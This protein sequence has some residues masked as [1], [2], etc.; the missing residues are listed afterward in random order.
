MRT[1]VL[2]GMLLACGMVVVLGSEN[3]NRAA[4]GTQANAS[5][6]TEKVK[7]EPEA[8]KNETL[9]IAVRG[10]AL[11]SDGKPISGAQIYLASVGEMGKLVA[12]TKTDGEGRYEFRS[13]ELP[14]QDFKSVGGAKHGEFQVFGR[15]S[16]YGF[17]WY[18][19]R[20]LFLKP[21]PAD[22]DERSDE[23]VPQPS[24]RFVVGD[25][26]EIDLSFLPAAK[27]SGRI[28]DD[29]AKPITGAELTI[30]GCEPLKDKLGTWQTGFSAVR[31]RSAVVPTDMKTCRTSDTGRFEFRGLPADCR[32][33]IN[34]HAEGF[35]E[36]GIWAATTDKPQPAEPQEPVVLTGDLQLRFR[37]P[38]DVPVKV[39]YGDTRKPAPRVRVTFYNSTD[40]A[41]AATDKEGLATLR[42]APGEYELSL[43]PVRGTS[44][45]ST[46]GILNPKLE[47][48]TVPNDSPAEPIVVFLRTGVIV[49]VKVVEAET[50][51]GVPHVDLWRQDDAN[52]PYNPAA[53]WSPGCESWD[54]D[55]QA[56]WAERPRTDKD[57]KL[58]G[59]FKSGVYRLG[60][61][62][63]NISAGFE[64]VE[65]EGQVVECAAGKPVSLKFTMRK[66]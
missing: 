47:R 56:V 36:R 40:K 9:P 46:P 39:L 55:T 24:Q 58:R 41:S 26:I 65:S 54:P 66:R 34:V 15:A 64:V 11:D 1:I 28:V 32:F 27:L 63:T 14:V 8:A 42:L 18:P 6:D 35:P 45:L 4:G 12:E 49:D 20:W 53:R 38:V 59:V 29:H 23:P 7:A 16:G 31:F 10:R 37:R 44:Y 57:G 48:V 62:F 51:A 17:A 33:R 2:E 25:K 50:G 22:L 13:A 21:V 3:P 43:L 61:G 52:N 19:Q 60:V 30:W 5:T